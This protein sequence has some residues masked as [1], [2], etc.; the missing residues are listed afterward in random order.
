MFGDRK[1]LF[2]EEKKNGG[3]KVGKYLEKEN[4]LFVEEKKT[5]K[6]KGGEYLEKEREENI[7]RRK[8]RKIFG[9]GKGGKY[10]EKENIFFCGGK[11]KRTRK[12]RKIF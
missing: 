12:K 8:G 2:W 9:E 7:W 1:Y 3:G 11:E 4:I 5:G 6:G 10:L